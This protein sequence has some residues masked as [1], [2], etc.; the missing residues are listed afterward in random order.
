[1]KRSS[2]PYDGFLFRSAG[3]LVT[4]R[5]GVGGGVGLYDITY[6]KIPLQDGL[7]YNVS[8][9]AF[10]TPPPASIIRATAVF[11]VQDAKI[12]AYAN[13][14]QQYTLSYTRE[15]RGGVTVA[16][17]P[18]F[19]RIAYDGPLAAFG[20]TRL[21]L[22]YTGQIAVLDRKIDWEGFTPRLVYTYTQNDST[23][24]L[25]SFHRNRIEVGL[26]RAF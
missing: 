10:Y 5:L 26:T 9:N 14:T 8:V 18:S 6:P 17:A 2:A 11:G 1:M 7:G 4:T 21:D 16:I 12:T 15:F 25:Y 20:V 19:T 23:I 22:Q 13:H 3:Q 24:P